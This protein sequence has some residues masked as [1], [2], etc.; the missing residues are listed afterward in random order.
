MHSK[1]WAANVIC[2]H[3]HQFAKL[4]HVGKAFIFHFKLKKTW[5][6]N[7]ELAHKGY[8]FKL[9]SSKFSLLQKISFLFSYLV[10]QYNML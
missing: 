3:M 8:F 9:D 10:V 2:W 6:K 7:Q 5:K 1:H 4:S